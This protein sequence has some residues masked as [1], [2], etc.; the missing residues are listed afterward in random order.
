MTN[1]LKEILKNHP[2]V[3]T[4]FVSL[5]EMLSAMPTDF[6]P[7]DPDRIAIFA[8]RL[9]SSRKNVIERNKQIVEWEGRQISGPRYCAVH[10]LSDVATWL[11]V[12]PQMVSNYGNGK[13][14]QIPT[15]HLIAFYDMFDVTPHYLV[16]YASKPEG[17]VVLDKI[18]K[19]YS[20]MTVV[21]VRLFIL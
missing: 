10:T 3:D 6:D 21:F 4:E 9:R 13:I 19:L 17:I 14:K 5:Y 15:Q 16:G 12:T 11:G 2:I 1:K 7:C 8:D 20:K 18:T